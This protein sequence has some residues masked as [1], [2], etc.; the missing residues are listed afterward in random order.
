[1]NLELE[2][3]YELPDSAAFERLR[4]RLERQAS[5][6][7]TLHQTNH[8]F[9]SADRRLARGLAILRIRI[10]DRAILAYKKG[11]EVEPGQ[12]RS[13]E[14]EVAL[15]EAEVET[16]LADPRALLALPHEPVQELLVDHPDL[17][18]TQL[19]TLI[20]HRHV[21]ELDGRRL[22]LDHLRFGD[23]H[24][25]FEL[26]LESDD[27]AEAARWCQQ[28]LESENLPVLPS[29]L[30]KLHRFLRWRGESGGE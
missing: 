17:V 22:E 1:M 19:G 4:A 16:V 7:R 28:L 18:L 11:E 26:E 30:T 13:Q 9:D 25:E 12:F 10:T 14:F 27:M 2:V 29:R 23:S 24:E 15:E 8:Y 21:F 20:N 6:T 5:E 3:K